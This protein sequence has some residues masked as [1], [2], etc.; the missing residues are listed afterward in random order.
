MP[1]PA[2]R[3][4]MGKLTHFSV[5]CSGQHVEVGFTD[6]TGEAV[7]LHLWGRFAEENAKQNWNNRFSSFKPYLM[8]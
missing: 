1:D 5:C 4:G 8:Q 3:L 6:H 7:S 2:R